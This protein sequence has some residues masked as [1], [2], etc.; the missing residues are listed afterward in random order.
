[1]EQPP[2]ISWSIGRVTCPIT[3]FN[4]IDM[5]QR[6]RMNGMQ[7][8]GSKKKNHLKQYFNASELALY[9]SKKDQCDICTGYEVGNIQYNAYQFH[10]N[11]EER[12]SA[13]SGKK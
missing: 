6:T 8:V 7:H 2:S 11:E 1:M 4:S 13:R 10:Y 9:K 5:S 12:G 3:N